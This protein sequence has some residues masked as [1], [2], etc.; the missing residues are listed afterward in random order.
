MNPVNRFVRWARTHPLALDATLALGVLL[1]MV[2]GSFVDPHGP[3]GT[4]AWGARTPNVL[5]LVLM[6]LGAAALV[7]RR[8]APS[9]YS[10]RPP[11]SPSSNWSQ[12][13][14]APPS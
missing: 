3:E 14:P 9:A 7:F 2:A 13:T 4:Y 8:R 6:L 12:A 1:C 5:S 10:R 11:P